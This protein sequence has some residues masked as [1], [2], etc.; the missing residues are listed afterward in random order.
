[1]EKKFLQ[2]TYKKVIVNYIPH[3]LIS[4][5]K[6]QTSDFIQYVSQLNLRGYFES[7]LERTSLSF[8]FLFRGVLYNSFGYDPHQVF[9]PEKLKCLIHDILSEFYSFRKDGYVNQQN[10]ERNKIFMIFKSFY[11]VY[12]DIFN[13][14]NS[15]R[16]SILSELEHM[17]NLV[18]I[19]LLYDIE[20]T[21]RV[22]ESRYSSEKLLSSK[23][24]RETLDR[25]R[26]IL[27]DL[28]DERSQ[29]QKTLSGGIRISLSKNRVLYIR[30]IY[31]GFDTEYKPVDSQ[32]NR[33]LCYTTASIPEC[34]LKIRSND[35][36]FSLK[37]GKVFLPKTAPL[38]KIGVALIRF[39]R[40]KKDF[41]VSELTRL[42]SK[43]SS[44]ECLRQS[45][46]DLVYRVKSFDFNQI[47]SR[48]IGL[49]TIPEEYSFKK[50]MDLVLED[51][52]DLK[53]SVFL[54]M[55]HR[56]NIKPTLK[57]EC[58]LLAHFTTADV[59]LFH[60]FEGIKTNFSVISKSFLTLDKFLT[61]KGWRIF[62][63]DTSLLSPGGMSL[64][65]IGLLYPTLPLKKIELSKEQYSDMEVMLNENP[66][67]FKEYAEQDAKIVL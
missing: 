33:L 21:L 55:T 11:P 56:L 12:T 10:L 20:V 54:E 37:E 26:E 13:T 47:Q 63:R 42:L 16:L 52:H 45:N 60:D 41:E 40:N 50:L 22:V 9:C 31:A 25:T 57:N 34:L 64:K 61:Y 66:L 2:K 67:L 24:G 58:T 59:S 43:E 51:Y 38:I 62:L 5:L 3:Y 36:D 49:T 4:S 1:M 32:T 28:K 48:Y 35:V 65:S 18:I 17:H 7:D 44:L 46:G 6:C 14:K 30:R 23:V 19:F 15:F 8:Y 29:L 53:N 39:L 27:F